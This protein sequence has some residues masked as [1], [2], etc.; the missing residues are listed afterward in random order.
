MTD[1]MLWWLASGAAV[2]LELLTGT[3]FLLMLA[4]GAAAGAIAAHLGWSPTAQ[5][6]TAAV[7]GG[8]AVALWGR[9]RRREAKGPPAQAD[10][11][12]VLDVGQVV[13]IEAWKP[14]GTA[15]VRYRGADWRAEPAPGAARQSGAYRI[16]AVQGNRLIVEPI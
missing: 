1:W 6:A 9:W 14:D 2:V 10:P 11:N 5:I 13:H 8:G 4:L 16:T 12:M 3:F 7:I 15:L